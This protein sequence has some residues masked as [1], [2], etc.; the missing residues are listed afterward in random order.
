[1]RFSKVAREG[2]THVVIDM[3]APYM[4]LIKEVFLNAKIVLDKF[5]IVQLLS[6]A[7]NKTRIRFMNQ[8]KE[9]YNKFK[10]YWRL[11]LKAQEEINSTNYFYSKC[12]KRHI[13][14]QEIIDFLLAL[15]P[16]LKATYDF[17]Q[18]IKHT[19]KLYNF[20]VFHHAIQHPS[21]LLSTEVKTAFK[22]LTNYQDYAKNT[23]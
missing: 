2:V 19:I 17:Y 8:N 6:R 15:D 1:M 21:D 10:H 13:S 20:E 5:H 4:T 9:F 16:E 3:Y 12:F 22:T 23:I 14:Q 18:T 11:L 7:L